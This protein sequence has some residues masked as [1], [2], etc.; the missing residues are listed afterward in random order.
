MPGNVPLAV[1]PGVEL[2]RVAD[3]ASEHAQAAGHPGRVQLLDSAYD[4]VAMNFNP[5]IIAFKDFARLERRMKSV[6]PPRKRK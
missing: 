4:E 2:A 3:E 6:T 5:E 1:Q